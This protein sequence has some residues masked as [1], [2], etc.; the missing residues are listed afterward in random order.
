MLAV[1]SIPAAFDRVQKWLDVLDTVDEDASEQVFI[2]FVE[3]GKAEEIGDVLNQV[4]LGGSSG[5][6]MMGAQDYQSRTRG[7]LGSRRS[8]QDS[9][10]FSG[11]SSS[12]RSG[13][14]GSSSSR[15]SGLSGSSSSRSSG[16]G[17]GGSNSRSSSRSRGSNR[18]SNRRSMG[19]Q[20]HVVPGGR[21]LDTA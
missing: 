6:G 20:G 16:G 9:G 5:G 12:S 21:G 3:N 19:R 15:S 11:S 4:Y 14:S 1:S 18:G 17:S 2:Y 10:S 8:G 13:L 7:G